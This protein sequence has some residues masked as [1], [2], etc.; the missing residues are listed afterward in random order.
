M[1][2]VTNKQKRVNLHGLK[3]STVVGLLNTCIYKVVLILRYPSICATLIN[4]FSAIP[5]IYQRIKFLYAFIHHS[6]SKEL[7]KHWTGWVQYVY[8][9][10]THVESVIKSFFAGKNGPCRNNLANS[11]PCSSIMC[12]PIPERYVTKLIP[13]ISNEGGSIAFLCCFS[14]CLIS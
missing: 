14:L 11:V 8:C 3:T 2:T 13:D 6:A 9:N 12:I 7:P 5:D 1:V 10:C 4:T